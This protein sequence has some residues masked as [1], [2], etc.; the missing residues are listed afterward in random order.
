MSCFAFPSVTVMVPLLTWVF[1]S[2]PSSM[3]SCCFDG[4]LGLPLFSKA[5]A[6]ETKGRISISAS[7]I[8]SSVEN[9]SLSKTFCIT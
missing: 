6:T 3:F 4:P 8:K 2:F 1:L 5:L 9:L 7:P